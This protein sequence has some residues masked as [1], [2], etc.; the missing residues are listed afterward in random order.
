ML[1][2]IRI[3]FKIGRIFMSL[4]LSST[5][6]GDGVC[7]RIFHAGVSDNLAEIKRTGMS[8]DQAAKF[9]IKKEID[10]YPLST[11]LETSI[12]NEWTYSGS[13]FI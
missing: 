10:K 9:C 2:P 12:L 7:S 5:P 4:G 3:R 11:D 1:L 13:P 8:I 6:I